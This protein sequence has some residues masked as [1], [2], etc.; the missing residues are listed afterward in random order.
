MVRPSVVSRQSSLACALVLAAAGASA[1]T[2]TP[3]RNVEIV[4]GSAP[5]GSN[6]RTARQVEKVLTENRLVGVTLTIV[7]RPGG[8]NNIAFNYV[9]QKAGDAHVLM[10]GTPT[11][12]TNHITGLGTLHHSDFTPVASLFNDYTVFAVN[13]SS[14]I[15]SDRDLV[16]RV[17]KDPKNVATGFA[18][19]L[20]THN[21]IAAC[22]LVKAVGGVP[23]DLKGVVFK[24]SA[25]AVVALLGGHIDLVTTAAGNAA[26][27]VAAGRVRVVA[28]A[29]P[30]RLGGALAA[31]PTWKEQGVDL[32]FGGWRAIMAPKGLTPAQVAYWEGVLRKATQAPEWR[33]DLEKNYWSDDFVTSAQF[34]KDLDKDYADMKSVLVDLGLAKQ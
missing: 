13:A 23:R 20:G 3:Q 16:E 31:V 12:L 34:R 17:K 15:R 24:G 25:E 30:K 4:V 21:H 5:G 10:I 27:H 19:G 9:H 7:N 32:V 8:S 33:D 28:A 22:L 2:W 11:L 29:A 26:P 1:Q 18:V 6:D 14:A